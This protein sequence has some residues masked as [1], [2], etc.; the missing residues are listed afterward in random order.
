M[1]TAPLS[2]TARKQGLS[3]AFAATYVNH[4]PDRVFKRPMT[5]QLLLVHD[6]YRS[7]R[8]R[9]RIVWVDGALE[10]RTGDFPGLGFHNLRGNFLLHCR[11]E[12]DRAAG[13]S[14]NKRYA[15]AYGRH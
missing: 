6:P 11:F 9:I 3:P 15:G 1:F 14:G 10:A 8:A 2:K 13:T 5:L 4:G 12:R 7:Q